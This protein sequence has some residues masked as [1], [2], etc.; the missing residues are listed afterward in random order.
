MLE[1]TGHLS[2]PIFER[3]GAAVP[4]DSKGPVCHVSKS[5]PAQRPNWVAREAKMMHPPFWIVCPAEAALG[6][7]VRTQQIF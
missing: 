5:L 6:W 3:C 1:Q 2:G 4:L 7:A